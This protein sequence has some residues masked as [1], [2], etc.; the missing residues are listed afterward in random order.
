MVEE[1]VISCL[2]DS[3]SSGYTL[4]KRQQI[5][6][7]LVLDVAT[8]DQCFLVSLTSILFFLN[9]LCSSLLF[10]FNYFIFNYKIINLQCC[11]V[12]WIWRNSTDEPIW[13]I[14]IGTLTRQETQAWSLGQEDALEKGM[15]SHYSILAWRTLWTEETW[16]ATIHKDARAR[17]ELATKPLPSLTYTLPWVNSIARRKLLYNP[18]SSDPCS[19]T[20]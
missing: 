19:V 20:I 12:F 4:V 9:F 6:S 17:H 1:S 7:T 8:V 10:I 16:W 2:E 3:F 11:V 14:G 13:G 18:G 5:V 15:A